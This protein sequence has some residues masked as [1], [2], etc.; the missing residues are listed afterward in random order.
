MA[1]LP[2]HAFEHEPELA[3]RR[4]IFRCSIEMN[5]NDTISRLDIRRKCSRTMSGETL[6]Y[7]A[8]LLKCRSRSRRQFPMPSSPPSPRNPETLLKCPYGGMGTLARCALKSRRKMVEDGVLTRFVDES[9]CRWNRPGGKRRCSTAPIRFPD[10]ADY[11]AQAVINACTEIRS[12]RN[13]LKMSSNTL[14]LTGSE[15]NATGAV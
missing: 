15:V 11:V 4:W 8:N 2:A 3:P 5:R 9:L 7:Y 13:I 12:A 14:C 6:A 1:I 10:I